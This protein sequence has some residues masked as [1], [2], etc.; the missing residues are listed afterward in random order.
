V[1]VSRRD[2][3]RDEGYFRNYSSDLGDFG[4]WTENPRVGGSIPPLATISS[5]VNSGEMGV[6]RDS[7]DRAPGQ[8]SGEPRARRARLTDSHKKTSRAV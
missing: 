5:G 7:G 2:I 4:R 6:Y 1:E 8:L 3:G